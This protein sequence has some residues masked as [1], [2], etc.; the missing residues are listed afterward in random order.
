LLRRLTGLSL[1]IFG[2]GFVLGY[3]VLALSAGAFEF[4]HV[5]SWFVS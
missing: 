3:I 4:W 2:V 1:A 5:W